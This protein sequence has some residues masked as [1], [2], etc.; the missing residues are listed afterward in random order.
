M[1]TNLGKEDK[2]G[3]YI[4]EK[5]RARFIGEGT[6]ILGDVEIGEN[7]WVGYYCLLEGLNAPLLIGRNS[8]IASFATIYTHNTMWRDIGM[9][10]KIVSKVIIG[11][12]VHM[13]HGAAIIP[14]R[15]GEIVI[16]DHSIIQAYAVV[17]QSIPPWSIYRRDG[18]CVPIRKKS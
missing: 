7:S 8:V 17:S 9:G 5:I 3:S 18:R 16:G 11:E 13:G 12:N 14:K 10:E 2:R 6:I 1:A 4:G 15:S